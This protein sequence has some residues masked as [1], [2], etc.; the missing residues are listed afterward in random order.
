MSIRIAALLMSL[1]FLCLHACKEET[2]VIRDPL[3][4]VLS[5]DRPEIARVMQ[6][7]VKFEVQVLYTRIQRTKNSVVFEEYNYAEDPQ[8]YF[9]PASTVK[10]PIAILALEKLNEIDS[11]DRNTR[12][13]IEGDTVETTFAHDISAIF[14]I[15]DNAAN[16]RLLEFLGQ[17]DINKR[18]HSKEVGPVRIA[19]RL[20]Q[21]SEFLATKPLILYLNDSTLTPT[22]S[23]NNRAA[24]PLE[25]NGIEKGMAFI[26]DESSL[27][28][29]F[30]FAL[31][32]YYPL[33]T[34][35]EVLKRII[36][37]EAFSRGQQF[38]ITSEQREFLLRSM[39]SLPREAGHDPSKFPDAYGKFFIY[40]DSKKPIPGNIEIFNKVGFAYGTLTDC[41]YIRDVENDIEFLLT[42]TILVNENGIFNDDQYE[43]EEIGIPFLA[44]LGRGIYEFEQQQKEQS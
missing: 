36:F 7:P 43:Y 6:S 10:L 31:K 27:G 34:Q 38:S 1:V 15:S 24:V 5:S 28:E 13:Y 20:G 42:A 41:A 2:E 32:N 40:G 35:H 22:R 25:L 8:R 9:Y 14:A 39:K 19:H 30:S 11:L 26:E 16:N 12:F 44:A 18:L 17:D 29:P 23:I 37:P 33:R 4:H 3:L 21:H